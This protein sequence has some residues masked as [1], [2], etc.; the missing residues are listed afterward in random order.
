[1]AVPHAPRPR[2]VFDLDGTLTRVETLPFIASHFGLEAEI[3][4][5][6]RATVA[7]QVPFE[8]GF[9]TRVRALGH[10][11]VRDVAAI[12]RNVPLFDGLVEFIRA[13]ADA[14]VIA[15]SNLDCWVAGLAEIF[16]C[17][18]AMS[19]V[20]IVGDR[21]VGIRHLV[22]K[23]ALVAQLQEAGHTVIFIG[24]GANDAAAMRLSDCGIAVGLVHP[25]APALLDVCDHLVRDEAALHALLIELA[26]DASA[27]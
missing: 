4:D 11:N 12:V 27:S 20:N 2:F 22:D 19:R 23:A 9:A 6:T 7:G 21:V 14:C 16:G 25:P 3:A 1:M 8:E 10:L 26:D 24:D 17:E 15:T 18:M 13:H 5:L